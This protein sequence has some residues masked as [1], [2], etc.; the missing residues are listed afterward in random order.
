MS[1]AVVACMCGSSESRARNFLKHA[2]YPDWMSIRIYRG[3]EKSLSALN[4]L[5]ATRE[6]ED[7]KAFLNT[8]SKWVVIIGYDPYNVSWSD[9]T[10]NAPKSTIEAEYI[11]KN[12]S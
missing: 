5:P 12:F 2:G 6:K 4:Q 7:L 9:I 10:H 11:V 1:I 3:K 8:A